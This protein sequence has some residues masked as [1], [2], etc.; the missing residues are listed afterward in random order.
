MWEKEIDFKQLG[1][2]RSREIDS[3]SLVKQTLELLHYSVKKLESLSSTAKLSDLEDIE[4]DIEPD[5]AETDSDAASDVES[6]DIPEGAVL[7]LK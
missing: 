4:P 5:V 3:F 1:D 6:I 2:R 7:L